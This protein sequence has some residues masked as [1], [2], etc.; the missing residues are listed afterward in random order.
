MFR[1][2]EVDKMKIMIVEDRLDGESTNYRVTNEEI[3]TIKKFLNLG[4]IE[5][6]LE[7]NKISID[8]VDEIEI[9]DF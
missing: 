6:T 7:D 5:D 3:A 1:K 4:R 9:K 8:F 2:N